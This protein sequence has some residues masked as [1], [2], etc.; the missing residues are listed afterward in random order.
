MMGLLSTIRGKKEAVIGSGIGSAQ[1]GP[2]NAK[3]KKLV[4]QE[5]PRWVILSMQDLKSNFQSLEPVSRL[6]PRDLA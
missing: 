6:V 5:W 2:L 3:T 1:V 4:I